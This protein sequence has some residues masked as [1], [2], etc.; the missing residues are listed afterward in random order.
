MSADDDARE[1]PPEGDLN[2]NEN[3]LL[4][5]LMNDP[6]KRRNVLRRMGVEAPE[7]DRTLSG[8]QDG[9]QQRHP[10]L[11]GK[12]MGAWHTPPPWWYGPPFFPFHPPAGFPPPPAGGATEQQ[13]PLDQSRAGPSRKRP[14]PSEELPEAADEEEDL[15]SVG[16]LSE[17][18]ALEMVEFDPSVDPE[19]SWEAPKA[20]E[21]RNTSIV[22][23]LTVREEPS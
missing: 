12:S 20:I 19:D 23:C 9:Q 14:A 22:H 1:D 4:E 11:S 16:L 21:A 17:A 10:T 8:K 3:A 15:D 13:A 7:P 6:D 18:E 2:D 5:E